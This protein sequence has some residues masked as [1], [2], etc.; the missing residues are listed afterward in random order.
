MYRRFMRHCLLRGLQT[1]LGQAWHLVVTAA[2]HSGSFR[3]QQL[4]DPDVYTR[5]HAPKKEATPD[6]KQTVILIN[7]C[8][9]GG[10][11]ENLDTPR[12]PFP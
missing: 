9:I 10:H 2:S 4:Q 5:V 6:P 3:T 8:D 7:G 1:R 11:P 12:G